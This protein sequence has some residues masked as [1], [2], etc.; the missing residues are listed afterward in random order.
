[1]DGTGPGDEEGQEGVGITVPDS[2]PTPTV[3]PSLAPTDF[4][5]D[6][7]GATVDLHWTDNAEGR[8]DYV[9]VYRTPGEEQQLVDIPRGVTSHPLRGLDPDAPYCFRLLGV[10]IDPEGELVRASADTAVRGCEARPADGEDD[11]DAT[12]TD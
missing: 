8:L 2:P 11:L 9:L 4:V 5:A 1:G 7:F 10:G 3:D 12:A 6:D